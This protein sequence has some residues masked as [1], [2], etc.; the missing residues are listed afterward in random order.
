MAAYCRVST[1]K[2]E[3][4]DSFAMQQKYYMDL[5]AGNPSWMLAG[6]Y[7]DEGR[8]GTSLCHREQL[9]RLMADARKGRMDLILVKSVSRFARNAVDCQKCVQ[10]LKRL[11]VEIFFEREAISNMD[12]ASDF[13]FSMLAVAAQEESRSISE[14]IRWRY[15]K[16]FRDGI[17]RMGNNRILGYNMDEEGR[18]IPNEDAWVISRVFQRYLEG[19]N[20]SQIAADITKMG[21]K[22]LRS[23]RPFDADTIRRILHN[24]TYVGDLQLQKRAPADYL[25]K[26]PMDHREYTTYYVSD[27]HPGIVDRKTWMMAKEKLEQAQ[28]QR[29]R[30]VMR[31]PSLSH[32]LY[33]LVFCGECREPMVRKTYVDKKKN[34]YKAWQCRAR[35]RGGSCKNPYIR[36]EIL[37]GELTAVLKEK[38]IFEEGLTKETAQRHIHMVFVGKKGISVELC[39]EAEAQ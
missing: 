17:F 31:N 28:A 2:E 18:L 33:G 24:V 6:I 37:V 9:L 15:T 19:M 16:N 29:R 21:G 30:G 26:Q 34:I 35:Q 25:T 38:G 13:V 23:S 36:E 10:E 11:G 32:F 14:N 4:K 12:A 5:I 7:G 1:D 22:R 3:Q 27:S 39:P 20:F 8:T